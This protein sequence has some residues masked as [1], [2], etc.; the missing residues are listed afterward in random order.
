MST[1][2]SVWAELVN[3]LLAGHAFLDSSLWLIKNKQIINSLVEISLRAH[4]LMEQGSGGPWF[5][6]IYACSP[7]TLG[8]I[9]KFIC[10]PPNMLGKKRGAKT[11]SGNSS[12]CPRPCTVGFEPTPLTKSKQDLNSLVKSIKSALINSFREWPT[13][14]YCIHN[15]WGGRVNALHP[16]HRAQGWAI[17]TCSGQAVLDSSLQ[18]I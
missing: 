1:T 18:N 14:I 13:P 17:F 8:R 4:F 11:R 2:Y 6:Y 12:T 16:F 15:P 10:S 9:G 3:L 7:I 5:Y